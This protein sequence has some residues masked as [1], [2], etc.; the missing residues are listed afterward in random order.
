MSHDSSSSCFFSWNG[1]TV[2][3]KKK[4][5]VH[6]GDMSICSVEFESENLCYFHCSCA[7]L[8]RKVHHGSHCVN[9]K[10]FFFKNK[11]TV[12]YL[13]WQGEY[14]SMSCLTCIGWQNWNAGD[15]SSF[16]KQLPAKQGVLAAA[17]QNTWYNKMSYWPATEP[18][19]FLCGRINF[20]LIKLGF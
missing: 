18:V 7:H 13:F 2:F 12:C 1:S 3:K 19:A 16:S 8:W 15:G 14:I 9:T 11:G 20:A 10:Q 6:D 5:A 17:W 4:K